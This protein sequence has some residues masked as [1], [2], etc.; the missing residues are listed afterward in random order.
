MLY[1]SFKVGLFFTYLVNSVI[2]VPA[3]FCN[4]HHYGGE[5]SDSISSHGSGSAELNNDCRRGVG[6]LYPMRDTKL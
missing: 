5:N 6:V 1:M 2:H 3:V 4:Q